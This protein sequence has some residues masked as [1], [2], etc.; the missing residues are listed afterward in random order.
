MVT[1]SSWRLRA[2]R[3]TPHLRAPARKYAEQLAD[4]RRACRI[5]YCDTVFFCDNVLDLTMAVVQSR[6]HD[7]RGTLHGRRAGA[8]LGRQPMCGEVA[9]EKLIH[10]SRVVDSECGKQSPYYLL[11]ALLRGG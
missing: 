1:S 10:R 4:M 11:V 3:P 9:C 2:V 7:S 6:M 8:K 5:A